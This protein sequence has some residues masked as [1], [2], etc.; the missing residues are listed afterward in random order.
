M[1]DQA[2]L[3][4]QAEAIISHA[5]TVDDVADVIS[6]GRAAAATVDLGREAYGI[7]CGMIPSLLH[8]VQEATID[9]LAEAIDAL[10]STAEDLRSTAR[11]YTGTD[12]RTAG[13]VRGGPG[14]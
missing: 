12:E 9:A 13:I 5:R 7:L 10:H 6:D 4:A 3:Q 1:A 11:D 8:P 2:G 14:R